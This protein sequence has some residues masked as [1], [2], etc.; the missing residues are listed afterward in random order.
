[1][2]QLQ[3]VNARASET[4]GMSVHV[5]TPRTGQKQWSLMA[6]SQLHVDWNLTSNT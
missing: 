3:C 4:N 2:Q 6:T 1:M 5:I